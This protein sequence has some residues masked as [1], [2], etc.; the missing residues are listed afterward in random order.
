[1]WRES[2]LP[3][4]VLPTSASLSLEQKATGSLVMVNFYSHFVSCSESANLSQVAGRWGVNLP[5]GCSG[6]GLAQGPAPALP[7]HRPPGPHQESGR[8]WSR[9]LWRGL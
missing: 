6:Q 7:T 4:W 8:S 2:S 3:P 5:G 1:M 9:G